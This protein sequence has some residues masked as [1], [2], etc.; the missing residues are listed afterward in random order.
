MCLTVAMFSGPWPVRRRARSSWKTTSMTQCRR[1]SMPQWART[2][3]AKVAASSWAEAEV[4]APGDG[5]LAVALDLG[6]DHGDG[7]EA[8]EARLAG[9]AAI[10]DE[11]VDV[12]ADGMTA[13]L[14]AAVVAVGGLERSRPRPARR[15]RSA[16]SRRAG[17]GQLS[18]TA[19]R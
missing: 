6:L 12:V 18:F 10:G 1:F 9:E 3:W 7:G 13:H 19:S 16:R 4:V 5:G 11:P 8:G 15:R 17:A 14:D 2:A